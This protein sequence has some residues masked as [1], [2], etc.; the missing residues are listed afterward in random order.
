MEHDARVK[1]HLKREDE[2]IRQGQD[3]L[4]PV[5]ESLTDQVLSNFSET[6]EFIQP[7]P[8]LAETL[9]D[10][11][12]VSWTSGILTGLDTFRSFDVKQDTPTTKALLTYMRLYGVSRAAKIINSTAAGLSREVLR[13]QRRGLSKAEIARNILNKLPQTVANRARIIAATEVHS[14]AQ[15]GMHHEATRS[16]RSLTK[17]W[18]TVEDDRVRDFSG[19][20]QYSHRLMHNKRAGL[21]RSFSVPSRDGSSELLR[22]PGDPNGSAGNIINC[23]CTVVYAEG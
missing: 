17:T 1:A 5:L 16:G 11:L 2:A 3:R 13:G 9:V 21:E 12:E 7:K 4:Y 18:I 14:A 6:G 10:A 8:Q 23:R 20:A 22:F 19:G 15:F